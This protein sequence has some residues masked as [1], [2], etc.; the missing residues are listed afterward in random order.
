MG[1][2]RTKRTKEDVEKW[3][4]KLAKDCGIE[5][6]ITF[7][8]NPQTEQINFVSIFDRDSLSD[9]GD[10]DGPAIDL[11]QKLKGFKQ[12]NLKDREDYIG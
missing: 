1:G 4:I 5:V 6:C 9:D 11:Q 8:V 2:R 3:M 7:K 10:D 12:R